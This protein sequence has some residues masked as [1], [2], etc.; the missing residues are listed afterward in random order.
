MNRTL[1]FEYF[2]LFMAYKGKLLWRRLY[3]TPS[4][5][6]FSLIDIGRSIVVHLQFA[7]IKH[8][9]N[10]ASVFL[11]IFYLSKHIHSIKLII[12]PNKETSFNRFILQEKS[13]LLMHSRLKILMYKRNKRLIRTSPWKK[14]NQKNY[15]IM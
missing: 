11:L 5:V 3:E 9:F 15:I 13:Y 8:P 2:L 14:L 10:H 4:M 7:N 1:A 6:I 12:E